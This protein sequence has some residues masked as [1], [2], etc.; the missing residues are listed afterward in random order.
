M[1][2]L[3]LLVVDGDVLTDISLIAD[4]KNLQVIMQV[5]EI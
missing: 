5:G 3:T 4:C 2:Y 1:P